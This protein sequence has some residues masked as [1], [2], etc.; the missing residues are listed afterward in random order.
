[1]AEVQTASRRPRLQRQRPLGTAILLHAEQPVGPTG[2][3]HGTAW[4]TDLPRFVA[5]LAVDGASN[6]VGALSLQEHVGLQ[7]ARIWPDCT[8]SWFRRHLA[9]HRGQ[10]GLGPFCPTCLDVPANLLAFYESRVG[11]GA[12]YLLHFDQPVGRK[13]QR[14]YVGFTTDIPRRLLQHRRGERVAC[15]PAR[16]AARLG[17]AVRL[18]K[19]WFPGSLELEQKLK[20]AG[21]LEHLCRICQAEGGSTQ[22]AS[23][24]RPAGQQAALPSASAQPWSSEDDQELLSAFAA[25]VRI[26][27]LAERL[28][29]SKPQVRARL[30]FYGKLTRWGARQ[31]TELRHAAAAGVPLAELAERF[32]RTPA[33]V[34]ARLDRHAD[35]EAQRRRYAHA[36]SS[37]TPELERELVRRFD[38]DQPISDIAKAL[39][40]T[41]GAIRKRLIRL[42]KL[43]PSGQPTARTVNGITEAESVQAAPPDTT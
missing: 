15:R 3:Q 30:T 2:V 26:A 1:M 29:R 34:R 20:A 18:A 42:G 6:L 43:D 21:D 11:Q 17:I 4:T 39:G 19:T 16:L 9:A 40:R 28:E 13:A 27:E 38:S 22:G 23:G 7:V 36:G 32:G 37:W 31:D 35:I 5:R 14:H 25:G 8:R 33:D 41:N 24:S 10:Y 12:C